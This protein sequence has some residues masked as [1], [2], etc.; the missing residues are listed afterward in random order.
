MCLP[1]CNSN[2]HM[3]VCNNLIPMHGMEKVKFVSPVAVF[4]STRH[5]P[6]W[7]TSIRMLLSDRKSCYWAPNRSIAINFFQEYVRIAESIVSVFLYLQ[8]PLL[9]FKIAYVDLIFITFIFLCINTSLR[10]WVIAETCRR[11]HVNINCNFI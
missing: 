6:T 10:T 1:Y 11:V 4:S 7:D 2:Q 8:T 9:T 5:S 3:Y